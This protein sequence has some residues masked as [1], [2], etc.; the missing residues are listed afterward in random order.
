MNALAPV[1]REGKLQPKLIGKG[2]AKA[3]RFDGFTTGEFVVKD[4][5]TRKQAMS[6]RTRG[7]TCPKIPISELLRLT[8]HQLT[9]K[10]KQAQL[11]LVLSN[12]I[13]AVGE[14]GSGLAVFSNELLRLRKA[15]QLLRSVGVSR[16]VI[17][18]DHGFLL[19]RPG[20]AELT[21]PHDNAKSRYALNQGPE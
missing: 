20:D 16:F 12:Q 10:I 14:K 4:W 11:V 1:V 5:R 17:T 21:A 6:Q 3:T 2:A 15:W 7:S 18:S 8:T 13:D 9:N 19:R